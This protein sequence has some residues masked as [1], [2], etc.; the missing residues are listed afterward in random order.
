MSLFF[1]SVSSFDPS[2]VILNLFGHMAG[3]FIEGTSISV[4][5][6]KP[7]VS[8]IAGRDGEVIAS[9]SNDKRATISISL[10]PSSLTNDF[11]SARLAIAQATKS[12]M[13]GIVALKDLNGSTML[14]SSK[15]WIIGWPSPIEFGSDAS[16]GTRKWDIRCAKL[17]PIIGGSL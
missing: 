17:A 7:Y 14:F 1:Q 10:L 13:D 6:E 3:G 15:S 4:A 11:L 12:V 16:V 5:F 2:K 8:D 9:I